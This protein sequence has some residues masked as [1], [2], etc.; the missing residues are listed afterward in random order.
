MQKQNIELVELLS[1]PRFSS[2]GNICLLLVKDG[3]DTLTDI[4]LSRGNM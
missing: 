1:P 2:S 3:W 4:G